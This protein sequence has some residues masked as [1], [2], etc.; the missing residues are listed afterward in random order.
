M[1][2]VI[3][4]ATGKVGRATIRKLR[5]EGATVRAVLR[6][7]SKA[8]PFADLGCEIAYADIR[9]A[10]ALA[11]AMRD[12]KAVQLICPATPQAANVAADMLQSI[13]A[14]GDAIDSARPPLVLAISDYGA[15]LPGDTG[16]TR[17]FHAMEKR[18][19]LTRSQLIFLR[20]A[21][22]MENW[23]RFLKVAAET[24]VLPSMHHPLTKEM[25][26]VSAT[27]IGTMSA[28]LLLEGGAEMAS[29]R[30]VHGEGP[31]RYTPLDVAEAMTSLLERPITARELPRDQWRQALMRG[32]LSQSYADLIV[33]LNDAHNT[34]QIDVESGV[35]EI[36]HA[37]TAVLAA[38]MRA[39][40][41]AIGNGAPRP[42][43]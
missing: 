2:F 24:G 32:G 40:S 17:F 4:G 7:P 27:D 19:L 36:R 1:M 34:G 6:D 30:I 37:P 43:K 9:D 13:A 33:T 16:I 39:N 41:G 14:M 12:A 10:S 29:P 28:A 3:L 21:E 23:G 35:G 18:L 38:L 26:I 15:H 42:D 5:H 8:A 22:H 25:P 20:S 31:R 11:I